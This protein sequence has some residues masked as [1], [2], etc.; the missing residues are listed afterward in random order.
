MKEHIADMFQ[1]WE[2]TL[3][4]SCLQ[5]VMG[6]VHTNAEEDAAMASIGVFAF[7][8]GNPSEELVLYKQGNYTQGFVIMDY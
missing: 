2:E 3:I 7:P 6:E 4:W 8:A 1:D 5:G